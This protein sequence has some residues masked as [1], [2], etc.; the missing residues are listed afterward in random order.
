MNPL[1]NSLNNSNGMLQQLQ[2]FRN[3]PSQFL[4]SRNIQIPNQYLNNPRE[5]VQYLM[6]TGRMSQSSLNQLMGMA[7]QMGIKF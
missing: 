1:Y 4:L 2:M 7:S 6:N 5:A 3:N